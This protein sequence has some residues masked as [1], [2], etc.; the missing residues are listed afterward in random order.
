MKKE[1]NI[2]RIIIWVITFLITFLALINEEIQV[3]IFFATVFTLS[4]FMASF[5]F[6]WLSKIMIRHGNKM[7]SKVKKIVYY[8]GIFVI[9]VAVVAAVGGFVAFLDTLTDYPNDLGSSLGRALGVLMLIGALGLMMLVP[10]IQT[11]LVLLISK[12][13]KTST[14]EV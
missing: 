14:D 8:V 13:T 7:K 3:R 9:D 10:Y 2:S 1:Y 5:A 6:T 4:T 11:L 12:F